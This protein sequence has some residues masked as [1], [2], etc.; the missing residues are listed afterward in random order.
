MCYKHEAVKK[1][2]RRNKQKYFC[3]NCQ[4]YFHRDLI[5]QKTIS[6]KQLVK[7]HLDGMSY[8]KLEA[9]TGMQKKKL[10]QAVNAKISTVPNTLEITK[11]LISKLGYSGKHVVDGKY[12]P[13]KEVVLEDRG[14]NIPRSKKRRKVFKGKVLIWGAD[15][16]THDILNFE[17]GD[18]ESVFS[19]NR[20]FKRLKEVGYLINSLTIDDKKEIERAAKRHFPKCV[21]QLCLKHYKAKINRVLKISHIKVKIRAKEKQLEKLFVSKR[22][23]YIPGSRPY[24]LRQAGRLINEIWDLSFRYELLLDFQDVIF[25]VLDAKSYEIALARMESL[26]KY[27]WPRRRAMCFPKEHIRIVRKLLLDFRENQEYLLNYL[28]YPHLDIPYTTNLIE[29]IN[30]QLELRLSS[31]RGFETEK[32][33]ENYLNA[34]IVKR[35]LTEFTDCR[36]QFRKLNGKSSLECAGADIL[37]VRKIKKQLGF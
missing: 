28:K 17:I 32:T 23:E 16:E 7:D 34:W 5:R 24:S 2:V 13:V 19:F 21:I 12:I 9:R 4:K 31:I 26:E 8:R 30:S 20:Y 6:P 35:R 37:D 33:A 27:F 11:S 25:S 36:G 14:G 18:S 15:Y 29:G 10:Y 22:S 1:G 3:Q